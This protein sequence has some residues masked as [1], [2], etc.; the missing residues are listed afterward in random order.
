METQKIELRGRLDVAIVYKFSFGSWVFLCLLNNIYFDLFAF[1]VNL[2]ADNHK[3]TLF[4]SLF[5]TCSLFTP[6]ISSR[7]QYIRKLN[8]LLEFG[9]SF[10]KIRNKSGPSIDPCGTLLCMP[11]ISEIH[12]SYCTNCL[13]SSY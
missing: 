13:R 6:S 2:I 10:V 5:K 1:S 4:N 8:K 11:F 7:Q 3:C 12:S 9:I